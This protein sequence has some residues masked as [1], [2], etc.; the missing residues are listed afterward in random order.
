MVGA[1]PAS[2][3]TVL[4][5]SGEAGG[6]F[7]R[8][9]LGH[10]RLR[11]VSVGAS[12]AG[13]G[14]RTTSRRPE[15]RG[16]SCV[17]AQSDRLHAAEIER[18]LPGDVRILLRTTAVGRARGVLVVAHA[19][20]HDGSSERDLAAAFRECYADEPFVR[21]TGAR[22]GSHRVPGPE[23]SRSTS[24]CDLGWALDRD[25][26]RAVLS[27]TLDDLGGGVGRALQALGLALG[28]DERLGFDAGTPHP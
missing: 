11:V 14:E 18:A 2:T 10:P 8:L 9:A 7:L 6:E 24:C 15:R 27:A 22:S 3:V 4:G 16:P 12:S 1:A 19:P 26:S 17:L 5:G 21:V 20:V 28:W 25:S 13:A 23:F